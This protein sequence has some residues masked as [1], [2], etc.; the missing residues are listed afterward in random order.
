MHKRQA[1]DERTLQ[2]DSLLAEVRIEAANVAACY[3]PLDNGRYEVKPGL[4]PFGT[5]LG[6]DRA[7]KQ[8]FQIDSNFAHYRQAKLLARAEK[9]SKYYQNYNY[10]GVAGAIARLI[11]SR[12]TQEYP[13]YFHLER[14][15][16]GN[17]ALHCSLTEETLYLN[18]D[19]QLQ[20]VQSKVIPAYTSTFD[21]LANQVQEDLAVVCRGSNGANWLGAIHLCYPNHW[22]AEEKIGKDF[23][24]V[25]APVAGIEK[26]N[27]RADAIVNT[28][29]AREA[30]IRFA[31][32]LSTDTRRNHHPKPPTGIQ[33]AQ[34]QGREFNLDNPQLY[35]RI[36]R[37][38]IWGLSKYAAALFIIRTYFQDCNVIKQNPILRSKLLAALDSMTIDSLIY[39]GLSD[40]KSDIIWWLNN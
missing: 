10:C 40:I 5:D 22:A 15:S 4:M 13:N 16:L 34:W 11:I 19:W 38:T 8:V 25:H 6:N 31:W 7:D 24:A 37:Q 21:A 32:G 33:V 30:T 28:M 18:A 12:L 1:V 39:K 9:L 20:Q 35:L 3:F 2:L 17:F 27:Q 29:I 14:L 36:E 23:A 26:I